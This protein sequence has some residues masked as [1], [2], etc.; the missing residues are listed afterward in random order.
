VASL[1]VASYDLSIDLTGGGDTFRSLAE[2]RF[3]CGEAGASAT[4]D[5]SALNIG[6]ADL[7]GTSIRDDVSGDGHLYLHRLEAE[8]TLIVEAE[9]GYATAGSVGLIRGYGSDGS[10]YVCSRAYPGG[11]PHM[12]CCFDKTD[13]RAPVSLSIRAPG[14]CTCVANGPLAGRSSDG[15]AEVWTFAPTRP[16]APYL[17]SM[18]AGLSAGPAFACARS[19]GSLVPVST[20][21]LP[22][23]AGQLAGALTGELFQQPLSFYE[24][25]LGVPFPDRKWDNAFVPEFTPLAF[26]APGLVTVREAVLSQQDD[27][28]IYLATVFGHE[29]GHAWFGGVAEFQPATDE[30]LE[31]AVVTYISRSA[32]AARYPDVDPWS[33]RTSPMLPDDAYAPGGARVRQLETM[34]G[35]QAVMEGLGRLVRNAAYRAVSRAD[36]VRSWSAAS[37][38][39]LSDW[40]ATELQL[41]P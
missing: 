6:R 26:G 38:R 39:E 7:N 2:I 10:S 35:R 3:G 8:N 19:D 24:R 28:E 40:A 36:L 5:L 12:F 37:G 4:A 41:E 21:A 29:L 9:F 1:R 34:I 14:G 22:S 30:W 13:A 23:A 20:Y 18:C 17:F 16:I 33:A 32:L 15:T 27:P 25:S 31:E 11:A